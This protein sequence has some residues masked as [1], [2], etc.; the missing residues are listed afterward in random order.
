MKYISI[1]LLIITFFSCSKEKIEKSIIEETNWNQVWESNFEPVVVDDF[2]SVRAEFHKPEKNPAHE[3]IITP[4]MSFGTGHHAT[5]Y[6][7]IEQMR[8]LDF[9]DK[10]VFDFGTGTGILAILAHKMGAGRVE[11]IDVDEWSIDNARENFDRNGCTKCE[12]T[13][14]TIIPNKHFDIILANINR[15]VLLQYASSLNAATK[16]A[17]YLL[18]SGLMIDDEGDITKEFMQQG[19]RLVKQSQRNNWICLLFAKGS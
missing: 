2:V 7:M 9:K 6:M 13:L 14:S 8:D 11:A 10:E 5:T 19:F 15:N 18:L 3:I 17:A 4:K 1:I 16:D 12:V